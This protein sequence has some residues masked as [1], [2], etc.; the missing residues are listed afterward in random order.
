MADAT[1]QAAALCEVTGSNAARCCLSDGRHWIFCLYQ[2]YAEGSLRSYEGSVRTIMEPKSG[3]GI[4]DLLEAD[5]YKVVTLVYH[6]LYDDGDP[7]KDSLY[8][9]HDIE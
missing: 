1:G 4:Q 9:L 3:L 5:V 7:F 8:S 2:K 6:W